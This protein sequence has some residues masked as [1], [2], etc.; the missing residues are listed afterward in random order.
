MPVARQDAQR[1]RQPHPGPPRSTDCRLAR[2]IAAYSKARTR[3]PEV[4]K[5]MAKEIGRQGSRLAD[6]TME[7]ARPPGLPG[8]R[9]HVLD[10][11]HPRESAGLSA[12]NNRHEGLGFP[13]M[14]AVA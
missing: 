10:A 9:N 3:F 14:R 11:R 6:P 5:R 8:G 2:L 4:M 13:L 7:L 1:S 12:G